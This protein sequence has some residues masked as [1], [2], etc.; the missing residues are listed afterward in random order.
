VTRLLDRID[1]PTDLHSLSDE[2][3]AQVAQE[4]RE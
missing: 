2:E 1:G 3:L 4:V